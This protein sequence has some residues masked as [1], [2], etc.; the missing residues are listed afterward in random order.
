M[1]LT[2]ITISHSGY[3][4]IYSYLIFIAFYIVLVYSHF[5]WLTCTH[6]SQERRFQ[7]FY[8]I[9]WIVNAKML[10]ILIL[11]QPL[12]PTE[13][14]HQVMVMEGPKLLNYKTYQPEQ[15][16]LKAT[17]SYHHQPLTTT[18]LSRTKSQFIQQIY[19][20]YPIRPQHH[21][22]TLFQTFLRALHNL[23]ME[24]VN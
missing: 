4:I 16:Y 5:R 20:S 13:V 24:L 3:F 2:I 11:L 12:D 15:T 8:Y 1:H 9:A 14:T 18:Y 19:Q 7:S 17:K 21:L 10:L 6:S 22:T 23:S